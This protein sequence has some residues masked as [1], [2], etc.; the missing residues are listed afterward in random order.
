MPRRSLFTLILIGATLLLAGLIVTDWLPLLRGPAPETSEW[1]WLYELRPQ[2]RWWLPLLTAAGLWL[3]SI[4][5]L[6]Q[7]R[8]YGLGL[9]GL[10]MGSLALQLALVYAHRP[11]V[12]A[13]LVDRTLSDATNGYFSVAANSSDMSGLLREF[14]RVMPTLSSEHTRTHP[15]GLVLA[16]WL[17]IRWG[18]AA[19]SLASTV[20]P[21]RCTDLWLLNQPPATATALLIWSFLP[22]VAAAFTVVPVYYL[23]L[24]LADEPAARLAALF[25][26]ALP[27]L[28]IFAP[29]PDQIYVFLSTVTLLLWLIAIER[30]NALLA[31]LTGF[32]LSLSTFLSLGNG[33]FVV[34]LGVVVLLHPNRQLLMVNL[35]W[36]TSFAFG[37][38]SLWLIYWLGWGVT[39]WH[40][41]HVA[42]Q[43]HYELVT[44]LRRYDWWVVYNL[45]DLLIFAGPMVVV[46]FAAALLF[47]FRHMILPKVSTTRQTP[48]STLRKDTGLTLAL[49]L[50]ILALDLSGSAR[51]EVGRLWLFFMPLLAIIAA[52]QLVSL[53]AFQQVSQSATQP[54]VLSPQSSVLIFAAHLM[55]VLA[56]GLAWKPMEAVIVVAERPQMPTTAPT[57]EITVPF[58]ETIRLVGY[59]LDVSEA[60]P[61]GVLNVT[62]YWGAEGAAAR[63]YT[64]FTHLI[65]QNGELVAQKDNWPANGQWPPTCWQAGEIVVDPYTLSLPTQLQPGPYT[66]LVG[67]YDADTGIRLLTPEGRDMFLIA[68][69]LFENGE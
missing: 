40:L 54:S 17:T 27:A 18:A 5:W 19:S 28:L 22:L 42:L 49:A 60:G 10:I 16:Q 35:K 2:T 45:L 1:H 64:V 53:S 30:R 46:G 20:Y 13:E 41:A 63:P 7:H 48:G 44:S 21:L 3:F 61:G 65:N 36:L 32:L 68:E 34:V 69:G 11:Q 24:R 23:G 6:R 55:L 38:A 43:Q 66:L 56:I 15:P 57:H 25:T 50:L 52:K 26:A 33:A 47:T 12:A 14:P 4:W 62:L 51:G 9:A 8:W 67:L 59:D 58:G 29:T 31:F 37:L 39:P